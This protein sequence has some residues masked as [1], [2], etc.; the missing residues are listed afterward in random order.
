MHDVI[1]ELVAATLRPIMAEA[2]A[3]FQK[4]AV[5]SAILV[6]CALLAVIAPLLIGRGAGGNLELT[7]GDLE[8]ICR[9]PLEFANGAPVSAPGEL[10]F[11]DRF[12]ER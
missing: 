9:V 5:L 12:V 7:V 1:T 4:V 6:G 11:P 2:L 3:G 8:C 10:G